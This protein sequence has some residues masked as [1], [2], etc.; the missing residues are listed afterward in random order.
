MEGTVTCF[1]ADT[2]QIIDVQHISKAEK[3]EY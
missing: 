2:K 1:D 3:V